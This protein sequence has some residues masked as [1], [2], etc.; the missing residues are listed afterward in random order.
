MVLTK[1][2]SDALAPVSISKDWAGER[3]REYTQARRLSQ[4]KFVVVVVS[5]GVRYYEP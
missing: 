1:P 4:Q 5:G 3:M 2:E